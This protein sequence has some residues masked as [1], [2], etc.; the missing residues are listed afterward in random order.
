MLGRQFAL[1][2]SSIRVIDAFLV[3]CAHTRL[4]AFSLC[5]SLPLPLG[6]G[7]R[8]VPPLGLMQAVR[9]LGAAAALAATALRPVSVFAD[10]RDERPV[11]AAPLFVSSA[12]DGGRAACF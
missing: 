11:R 2:P 10:D 4:S 1:P 9:R 7:G 6:A 12:Q 5:R 8:V 3:K